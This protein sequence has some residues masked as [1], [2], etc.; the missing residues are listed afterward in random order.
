MIRFTLIFI[1]AASAFTSGCTYVPDM[2]ADSD[3]DHFIHTVLASD[4]TQ[5]YRPLP[6][7]TATDSPGPS[8]FDQFVARFFMIN[9]ADSFKAATANADEYRLASA[10]FI[11][12]LLR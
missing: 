7:S 10:D 3:A 2:V 4:R 5:A 9:T 1:M 12:L 6:A 8:A 11:L